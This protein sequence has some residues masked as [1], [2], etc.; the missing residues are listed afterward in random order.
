MFFE[1]H[2]SKD[3]TMSSVRAV[4]TKGASVVFSSAFLFALL[5]TTVWI[6]ASQVFRYFVF[7]MPMMHEALS[8]VGNFAPMDLIIFAG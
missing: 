6:N 3:L 5:V 7:V 2:H 4:P 1:I 8:G